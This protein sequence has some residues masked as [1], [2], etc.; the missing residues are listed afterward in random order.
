VAVVTGLVALLAGSFIGVVIARLPTGRSLIG[1]PSSCEHCGHRLAVR[2]LVPLVS[3]LASAGRCRYCGQALGAF[4]PLVELAALAV[5]GSALAVLPT[6]SWTLLVV[7]LGLGWTLLAL[8]W[9]DAR[10]LILPDA[11][12][13][14]LIAAGLGVAWLLDAPV[15]DRLI[16]ALVGFLALVAIAAGYRRVRR[17]PGMGLGDAKLM[18]AAGAWLGW[19]ALPGVLLVAALAG[20]LV[21][22]I[23]AGRRRQDWSRLRIPFG[24]PL[25]LAFWLTWL[26]GPIVVP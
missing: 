1:P 11:L 10:W 16:G 8:A 24:P 25:A 23:L 19:P 21:A 5:A 2:D 6:G 26:L 15:L 22:S 18:A 13:L 17:R 14:P 3:W 9:I 4:Y 20:L 7:S 12:T